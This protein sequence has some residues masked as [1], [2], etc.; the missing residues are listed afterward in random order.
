MSLNLLNWAQVGNLRPNDFAP[1]RAGTSLPLGPGGG[2]LL[3]NVGKD[4]GGP[5]DR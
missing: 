4:A 1:A 5:P 2:Q 3:R